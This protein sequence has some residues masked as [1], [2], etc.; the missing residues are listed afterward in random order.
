MKRN[1]QITIIL[2]G[3]VLIVRIVFV[4]IEQN[5]TFSKNAENNIK[6]SVQTKQSNGKETIKN[7]EIEI[8]EI[9]EKDTQEKILRKPEEETKTPKEIKKEI[10]KPEIIPKEYNIQNMDFFSQSPYGNRNQ[11]YQDAC[12][13]ASLLI[14]QYYIKGIKKTKE[15][16]NK[17]LLAMVELEMEMLG[18]FESTTIMEMKQIINRRDPSISARIIEHP[19]IHDLEREISQ[20]NVVVAPFYGKG[21]GNPHYA[22]GGPEYHFL[23]IKGYTTDSFITHDVGTMHGANRHY[24]KNL[25]MENI[26]DRNR[27]DVRKGAARVL[28][29][30]K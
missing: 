10:S 25:I 28:I 6:E 17:D 23:V 7:K 15:E 27:V 22:L 20:N 21:L 30:E 2:T 5:K 8:K 9:K 26:H 24:N 13:E 14:G 19:T 1:S 11:P 16:Y 4:F 12:E 3:L 29:L 18:Y